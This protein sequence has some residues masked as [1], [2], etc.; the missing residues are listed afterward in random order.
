MEASDRARKNNEVD[1]HDAADR[2]SELAS[3]CAHLNTEKRKLEANNA[4]LLADLEETVV[5]LKTCEERV[6]KS[7]DDANRLAEEL[8]MEQEH[9]LNVDKMRKGLEQQIRDLQVRLDEAEASA[10]K[11]GKRVIQKLE[12]RVSF[13]DWSRGLL[14]S[15]RGKASF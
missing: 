11:G 2:I 14:Y 8:R 7:T 3:S 10:L 6:R 12:Q 15:F 13:I 4:T 9:S 5:E 1:L